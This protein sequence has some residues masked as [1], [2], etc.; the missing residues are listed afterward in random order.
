MSRISAFET[1][2]PSILQLYHR[3]K[4]AFWEAVMA[5]F[6]SEKFS[7]S[8]LWSHVKVDVGILAAFR[9]IDD[10]ARKTLKEFGVPFGIDVTTWKSYRP[11]YLK[12][13]Y[14]VFAFLA[15][16]MA[17]EGLDDLIERFADVLKGGVFAVTGYGIL[18][19]NV[20]A[21]TPSPV[22]ILAA[23]A[24][25][26]E[27]ETLAL[28]GFGVTPV[29]LAIMHDMRSLF[30]NA[31]IKEKSARGKVSPYRLDD[32]KG[33]G[34]KAANA[35]A[36]FMLSLER[37][38]RVSMIKQYWDVFL[39][40]GA[41]IQMIDDWMDLEGDL[42]SGHYSYVTLGSEGSLDLGDPAG[43]AA[44]LRKDTSRVGSTYDTCKRMIGEARSLL[45]TLNDR[46][47]VRLVDVTELRV[48]SHFRDKLGLDI[49]L[50]SR[51]RSAGGR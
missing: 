33:L 47:L 13:A 31:E 10:E 46:F 4:E 24:L 26:A 30:L 32:P 2:A 45:H 11:S 15:V 38:G 3:D 42:A 51:P 35:V 41:A 19:M 9:G 16:W 48:D 18:D 39:L 44:R 49:P 37:L 50:P 17:E 8:S 27:Y 36:P 29:N 7:L 25:I 28:R 21:D 34:R 20:D 23:Y 14:P 5:P 43:T 6:L 22:E 40:F 1:F 12:D